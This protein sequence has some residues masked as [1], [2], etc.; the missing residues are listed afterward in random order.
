M[1]YWQLE[2]HDEARR[3]YELGLENQEKALPIAGT[4]LRRIRAE[5]EQLMSI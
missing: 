2:R 1:A 3:W 5:A 4:E